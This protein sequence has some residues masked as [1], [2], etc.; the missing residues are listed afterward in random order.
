M[1]HIVLLFCQEVNRVLI[2]WYLDQYVAIFV[3]NRKY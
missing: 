2:F 1:A 3:N